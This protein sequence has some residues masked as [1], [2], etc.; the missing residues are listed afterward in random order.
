MAAISWEC[1]HSRSSI[2]GQTF[3]AE[4]LPLSSSSEVQQLLEDIQSILERCLS[5]VRVMLDMATIFWLTV[6]I[7]RHCQDLARGDCLDSIANVSRC[8]GSADTA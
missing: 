4:P 7:T 1:H 2:A 3:S 6:S 8:A 5:F